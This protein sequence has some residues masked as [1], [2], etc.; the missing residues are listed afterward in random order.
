MAPSGIISEPSRPRALALA[1]LLFVLPAAWVTRSYSAA[2]RIVMPTATRRTIPKIGVRTPIALASYQALL[3]SAPVPISLGRN[4]FAFGGGLDHLARAA[5]SRHSPA[6]PA[7]P[8]HAVA[9]D[10][11]PT[12]AGVAEAASSS[13]A[14]LRTAVFMNG[15]GTVLFVA[16]G[17]LVGVS[18]RV[19]HIGPD[20]VVLMDT[21]TGATVHLRLQ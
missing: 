17:D 12:L 1:V 6:L 14:P 4:P 15:D 8:V 21:Q 3:R 19:F 7:A 11:L 10:P 2:G 13:H 20:I 16:E 5:A 18:H 9:A